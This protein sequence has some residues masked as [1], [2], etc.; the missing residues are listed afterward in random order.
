MGRDT[1]R[2]RSGTILR[3]QIYERDVLS[4]AELWQL[5][6]N[7]TESI[8]IWREESF[9]DA[10]R[11]CGFKR[12]Q[13]RSGYFSF[14]A[15]GHTAGQAKLLNGRV[16]EIR[17]FMGR[18][19]RDLGQELFEQ[20]RRKIPLL[21]TEYSDLFRSHLGSPRHAHDNDIFETK[22]HR[23]RVLASAEVWVVLSDLATLSNLNVD[24]WAAN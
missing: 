2:Y 4:P 18:E 23:V 13:A 9:V 19:P 8:A 1:S 22:T 17:L 7:V 6:C 11:K 3:M 14:E 12:I 20:D 21:A 5:Y 15:A 10:G 16:E 24:Y